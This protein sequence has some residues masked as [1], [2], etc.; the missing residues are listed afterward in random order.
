V[1]DPGVE[2]KR[3]FVVE[4][5]FANVLKQTERQG[6]TLSAVLRQGWET[7]NLRS[8]TKNSP[9]RATGAHIS[10]VGHI[11]DE[12]LRRY[13][14]ATESANGF[15][16]RF[17]WFLVRR[18]KLLPDGGTPDLAALA[19]VEGDLAEAMRFAQAAGEFRR[20]DRAGTLW[21]EVYP[22]LSA[23][24]HGLA[25]S[26]TG[27][28]EAHVLRLSLIYAVL[29]RAPC[30]RVE[31]LMAAL[32]VWQ[33][34]DESVLC[35]FG[36]STGNPLA[37][38][39]LVLLRNARSGLTRNEIREM[40]GKNLA[41]ERISQALGVLL[42]QGLARFERRETGGRPAELWFATTRGGTP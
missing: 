39:I 29:D 19:S 5:E 42:G 41:A 31:H 16:N 28:A 6:N 24:R 20:D 3:L 38:D 14:T 1:A 15:G 9:A 33:Y 2:D 26:L 18:S 32:A 35:L 23:D 21:R 17:M 25:G 8:L 11:T 22:V 30:V 13:L 7:G 10:I 40:V 37:D 34:A 36:D 27:R 4:P 12:E